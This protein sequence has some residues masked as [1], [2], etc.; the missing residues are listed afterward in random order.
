MNKLLIRSFAVIFIGLLVLTGVAM[1]NKLN[2]SMNE[3]DTAL[4]HLEQALGIEDNG[5]GNE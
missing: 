3:L 4:D 1:H 2:Q 5:D